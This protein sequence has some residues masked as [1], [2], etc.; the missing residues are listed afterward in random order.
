MKS[1]YVLDASL[2]VAWHD[3]AGGFDGWEVEAAGS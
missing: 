3:K 2:D 1:N